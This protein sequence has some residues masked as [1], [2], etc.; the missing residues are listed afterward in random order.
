MLYVMGDDCCTTSWLPARHPGPQGTLS[1]SEI[2]TLAMCGQWQ[3]FGSE[4][5]FYRHA[6][7]HLRA[8]FPQRP[9]REHFNRQ[10]REHHAARVAFFLDRGTLLAAQ[11]CADETLDSSGVPTRD[12]NRRGAGW[13]PGLA[14]IGWSN[15][16]GGYE[17]VNLVIAVNPV[18]VLTGVGFGPARSNDQPLAETFLAA[19]RHHHPGLPSVGAPALG[20]YVVDKGFEGQA[21]HATWWQIYGAQLICPP[22]RH[23]RAPWPKRLRRWLAGVRQIVETVSEKLW[24]TFRLDRARPITSVGCRRAWLG[25][26]TSCFVSYVCPPPSTTFFASCARP[27]AWT[28]GH[29]VGVDAVGFAPDVT[30]P[31]PQWERRQFGAPV[32]RTDGEA[33]AGTNGA[34]QWGDLGRLCA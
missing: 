30:L 28:I 3:G 7:R 13:W 9:T 23:S 33:M 2:V 32:A 16:L 14:D 6:Q 1:R 29:S 8:A 17:G 24:H 19:R 12:A 26:M 20:P 34:Q 27:C 22:K 10:V 18:R 4:R 5:G 15:R 31:H 25:R 11:R 21:Q